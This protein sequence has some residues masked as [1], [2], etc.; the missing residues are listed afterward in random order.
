MSKVKKAPTKGEFTLSKWTKSQLLL[1]PT[2]EPTDGTTVIPWIRKLDVIT[3][4]TNPTRFSPADVERAADIKASLRPTARD[5][6]A[7]YE[8]EQAVLAGKPGAEG[9]LRALEAAAAPK[10]RLLVGAFC[11]GPISTADECKTRVYD[12]PMPIASRGFT[13]VTA[14]ETQ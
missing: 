2:R 4:L 3:V 5:I 14:A 8:A 11:E 9:A 10:D 12:P 6:E 13:S 1:S 7:L